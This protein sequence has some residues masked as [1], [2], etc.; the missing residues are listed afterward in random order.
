[1]GRLRFVESE[2]VFGKN[3]TTRALLRMIFGNVGFIVIGVYV[4]TR[5][6]NLQF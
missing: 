2:N 1:M 3:A 5:I 4:S 6:M